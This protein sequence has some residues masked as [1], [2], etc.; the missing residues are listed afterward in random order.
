MT[1][2]TLNLQDLVWTGTPPAN[3][4]PLDTEALTNGSN[5]DTGF[6]SM[7]DNTHA[8]TPGPLRPQCRRPLRVSGIISSPAISGDSSDLRA[9]RNSGAGWGHTIML[10]ESDGKTSPNR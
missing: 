2:T 4:E 3:A 7:P 5:W 8:L 6:M 10:L 1:Q 9:S